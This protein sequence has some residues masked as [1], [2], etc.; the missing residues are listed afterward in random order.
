[1][2]DCYLNLLRITSLETISL[3]LD[4]E[5]TKSSQSSIIIDKSI[6]QGRMEGYAEILTSPLRPFPSAMT[7]M[8][9]SNQSSASVTESTTTTVPPTD[10][11]AVES[12]TATPTPAINIPTLDTKV[13]IEFSLS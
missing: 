9:S 12:T 13:N 4:T 7:I 5:M 11:V 8:T 1:M 2:Y 3:I 6:S 10:N